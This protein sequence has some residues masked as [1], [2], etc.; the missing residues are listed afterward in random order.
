MKKALLIAM[1]CLA[2][3]TMMACTSTASSA[4]STT[5]EE[6]APVPEPKVGP[7]VDAVH[8]TPQVIDGTMD[9]V[10]EKAPVIETTMLTTGDDKTANAKARLAWDDKFLYVYVEVTDPVLSD[11]STNS[12]EQDSVEIYIDEK[13]AKSASYTTGIAQ[14]RVNFKN[15]VSGGSGA[16]MSQFKTGVKIVDGGY[17]VTAA[18]PFVLGAPKAGSWIGF[19]FQTNDDGKGDGVRSG[20]KDWANTTNQNYQNASQFGNAKLLP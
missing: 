8:G 7:K 13:D 6:A 11:K 2:V 18:V 16:K 12:W 17:T 14:Y 19:D 10:F 9:P 15:V 3:L 5:K 20:I 1:A 4:A